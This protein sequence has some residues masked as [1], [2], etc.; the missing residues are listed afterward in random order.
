MSR[1]GQLVFVTG[2]GTGAG[3]TW[4]AAA[5]LTALRAAG[6]SVAA[7]KPAQSFTD[8][9]GPT[10]AEILAAATGEAPTAVCPPHRWYELAMAPPMAADA[11]GRPLF[12]IADLAAEIDWPEGVDIGFVEGAGGPRSPMAEDGDNLALARALA[13]DAVVLVA[14]AGLGTINAVQLCIDAGNDFPTGHV[15]PVIVALNRYDE[16]EELHRRNRGWLQERAA[17]DLVTAPSELAER[18]RSGA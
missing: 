8:D 16:G 9:T 12:S 6:T 11:L 5:T 15:P 13:P 1:P 18:L 14:D 2:T 3:K 7:R 4:F 17:L 10:D